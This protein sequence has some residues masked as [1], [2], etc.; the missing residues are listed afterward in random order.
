[1]KRKL[2]RS[3]QCIWLDENWSVPTGCSGVRGSI[4]GKK[5][6]RTVHLTAVQE[7][8][9]QHEN[10]GLTVALSKEKRP[11]KR[12]KPLLLNQPNE[13]RG[14]AVFWSPSSVQKTR[15]CL[16]QKEADE[17]QLQPP[18]NEAAEVRKTSNQ[19]KARLLQ[20]RRAVRAVARV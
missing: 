5:L 9:L 3:T 4:K 16:Q 1:M 11:M 20:E 15:D 7:Q 2:S 14:G 6:S 17:E 19:L 12:G 8:L 13:Y 18:K 10:E